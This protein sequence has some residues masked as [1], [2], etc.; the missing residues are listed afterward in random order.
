MG[1]KDQPEWMT[2]GRSADRRFLANLT[3][4]DEESSQ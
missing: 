1:K 4:T 2:D 3:V